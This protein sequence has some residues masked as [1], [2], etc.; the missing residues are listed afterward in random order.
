MAQFTQR[1]IQAL[2]KQQSKSMAAKLLGLLVLSCP[3]VIL[4][5]AA[6]TSRPPA[7]SWAVPASSGALPMYWFGQN[8]KAF[9]TDAYL[10]NLT[11]RFDLAIY[12]WQH[13][14]AAAPKNQQES[15]KLSQQ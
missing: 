15:Q 10:S 1:T 13:A 6:A 14:A 8:A 9:D 5:L 4:G 11:S 12:G 2:T 3:P 7:A